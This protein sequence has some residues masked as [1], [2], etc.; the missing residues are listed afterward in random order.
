MFDT[1]GGRRA[2]LSA[3]MVYSSFIIALLA[4]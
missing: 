1:F 3:P 4:A 2:I